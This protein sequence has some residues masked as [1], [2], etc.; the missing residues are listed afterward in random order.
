[1]AWKESFMACRVIHPRELPYLGEVSLTVSNIPWTF[2]HKKRQSQAYCIFSDDS[3]AQAACIP[4]L[5]TQRL[6]VEQQLFTSE[7][8]LGKREVLGE[9]WVRE[10]FVIQQKL[11]ASAGWL[12]KLCT[13]IILSVL[14]PCC[15]HF[16]A[17]A[18]TTINQLYCKQ[19]R[20]YYIETVQI[21]KWFGCCFFFPL[22]TYEFFTEIMWPEF[23]V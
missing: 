9:A 5:N 15:K 21:A 6:P 2:L 14:F 22:S 3:L 19:W 7:L 17:R 20:P 1:M 18:V 12:K 23:L 11:L 13:S 4:L 16:T 8:S 10:R